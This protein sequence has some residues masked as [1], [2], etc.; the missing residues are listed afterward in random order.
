LLSTETVSFG[1]RGCLPM[2]FIVN[3]S[4]IIN[5][6]HGVSLCDELGLGI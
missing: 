4:K 6:R 2:V 3:Q 5:L 1:L